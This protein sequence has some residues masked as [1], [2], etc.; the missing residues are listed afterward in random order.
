M[1]LSGVPVPAADGTVAAAEWLDFAFRS[2]AIDRLVHHFEGMGTGFAAMGVVA[3]IS[4]LVYPLHSL[5]SPRTT[6]ATTDNT[7]TAAPSSDGGGRPV[8]TY[9]AAVGLPSAAVWAFAVWAQRR[10]AWGLVPG[11]W[12]ALFCACVTLKITSFVAASAVATPPQTPPSPAGSSSDASSA[13]A[14]AAAAAAGPRSLTFGEYLFFLFLSPSLVCEVRLMKVSARRRSRPLRAASEFFHAVL[15]FLCAHC[16]V[17]SILAPSLRLFF[18]AVS[19]GW[20][21]GAAAGWAEL[22]AAGG[23][24]WPSWTAGSAL[25]AGGDKE[26]SG[27]RLGQLV[28]LG[29]FLWMLFVVSSALHF[30]VFYAFWHCICLGM[31]ELWGFPDRNLYGCWWLLFDEPRDF[32]RMWSTPVHRWLST[33][34]HWPMLELCSTSDEGVDGT[35]SPPSAELSTATAEVAGDPSKWTWVP[36]VLATFV[37]SGVFHE[38]VVYIAMRGTC[39][40]FNTFLLCVGGVLVIFWDIVFPLPDLKPSSESEG[41]SPPQTA[42]LSPRNEGGAGKKVV[43]AYGH[44]G[45]MSAAAFCVSV[46]LSAFIADCAAWL[47]WRH[48]H[49]KN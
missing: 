49:M 14:A 16:V 13:E 32:L 45:R 28:A 29:C 35:K 17:G 3:S 24:G 4:I 30:M 20:V 5:L 43:R 23:A 27:T 46:Q 11:L 47:W 31:A 21:E 19:P 41:G 7:A 44:R 39:W 10:A 6:P 36:A 12:L 1:A 25:L 8:G 26:D 33:C 42:T 48:I 22:E 18:S 15:T 40:P 2:M 34:V 38:A 9:V 37:V